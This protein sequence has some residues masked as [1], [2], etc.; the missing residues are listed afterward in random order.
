LFA[1]GGFLPAV[2]ARQ[3]RQLG[4]ALS[5]RLAGMARV[6]QRAAEASQRRSAAQQPL[7]LLRG[8]LRNVCSRHGARQGRT[9]QP[10]LADRRQACQQWPALSLACSFLSFAARQL[11]T[12]ELL[13]QPVV[14]LL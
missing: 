13:A 2:I 5:G 4:P 6:R 11:S 9:S 3:R 14:R 8:K 7:L 1:S 10:H 12:R